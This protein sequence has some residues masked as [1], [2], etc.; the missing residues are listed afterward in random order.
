[1]Y[2]KKYQI[3]VN[4]NLSQI[5]NIIENG[6]DIY[7]ISEELSIPY[8]SLR[9]YLKSID[10]NLPKK[11]GPNKGTSIY[12][13]QLK[14][15]DEVLKLIEEGDSLLNICKIMDL[16]YCYFY[17]IIKDKIDRSKSNIIKKRISESQSLFDYEEEQR[18]I[19]IYKTGQSI[20]T[21]GKMCDVSPATICNVLNKHDIKRNNQSIYWTE[22]RKKEYSKKGHNGEIGVH[23]QGNGAYRFTKPERD[24]AAWCEDNDIAYERQYQIQ[25]GTHRYDFILKGTNVLV[26]IDGEF[27]HCTEEQLQKDR[28]FEEFAKKNGYNVVRFTDKQMYET[29][30][31][32]FEILL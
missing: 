23:A 21:L 24:F 31:K 11:K 18:I 14:Y 15:L 7:N 6:G 2:P 4:D 9:S 12:D 16:N 27:W 1:M 32:C 28:S 19:N 5:N 17:N 26:E 8:H 30:L 13:Y 3:I 22:E 25:K 10:I 20:Y 29:R